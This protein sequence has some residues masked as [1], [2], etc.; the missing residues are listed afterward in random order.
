MNDFLHFGI[1]EVLCMAV[2]KG[3]IDCSVMVC[4]V[5]GTVIISK[6]ELIQGIDGKISGI[7]ETSPIPE[8]IGEIGEKNVLDPMHA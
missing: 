1:S 8:V 4:D 3:M 6:P 7:I 2:M 5:A